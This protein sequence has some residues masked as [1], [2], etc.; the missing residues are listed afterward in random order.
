MPSRK[1]L[2]IAVH[3][4]SCDTLK[5]SCKFDDLMN[6]STELGPSDFEGQRLKKNGTL[7][8]LFAA[9]WCHLC[10]SFRSIFNS[11]LSGKGMAGALADLSDPENPLWEQF[12][13]DVVPTV[14][15]FKE[16]EVVYRKDGMLGRG[17]PDNVMESA[18]EA[19]R[20]VL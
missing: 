16:G 12:G 5:V 6:A 8:V 15:V 7:A 2:S 19:Y 4:R 3:S 1:R 17:L 10:R 14:M 18:Y 11:A 20:G 13:I 9:E